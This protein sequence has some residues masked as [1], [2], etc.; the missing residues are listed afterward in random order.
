MSINNMNPNTFLDN[1]IS[2][3][4]IIS[5][6][7][8]S[9]PRLLTKIEKIRQ[10]AVKVKKVNSK[11]F[12]GDNVALKKYK[13]NQSKL[14][15][16]RMIKVL[17]G[18]GTVERSGGAYDGITEYEYDA[19]SEYKNGISAYGNSGNSVAKFNGQPF[20]GISMKQYAEFCFLKDGVCLKPITFGYEHPDIISG[21]KSVTKSALRAL[22]SSFQEQLQIGDG[23]EIKQSIGQIGQSIGQVGQ[24][25]GPVLETLIEVGDSTDE[26]KRQLVVSGIALQVILII[27]GIYL[28]TKIS[29]LIHHGLKNKFKNKSKSFLNECLHQKKSHARDFMNICLLSGFASLDVRD[30]LLV[31]KNDPKVLDRII[32][33]VK[34]SNK[35]L[36]NLKILPNILMCGYVHVLNPG[37][38]TIDE[39]YFLLC[40]CMGIVNT[41]VLDS[42]RDA[43]IMKEKVE[44][45][46]A[47]GDVH[48]TNDFLDQ[49]DQYLTVLRSIHKMLDR[50]NTNMH[51]LMPKNTKALFDF[52]ND[53]IVTA[54]TALSTNDYI[55]YATLLPVVGQRV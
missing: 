27:G 5:A 47:L 17:E 32:S 33:E 55:N 29:K 20:A 42:S 15:N 21:F 10:Q 23:S 38:I 40:T 28:T 19:I 2:M 8:K 53:F 11:T 25:I 36:P 46:M 35:D 34:L 41:N 14:I 44:Y 43:F 39:L 3:I 1:T 30:R 6:F 12:T 22:G 48:S 24:P 51:D 45:I 31:R 37:T 13:T 7:D 49:N 16:R 9:D 54:E 26:L 50:I 4:T 52:V 18:T